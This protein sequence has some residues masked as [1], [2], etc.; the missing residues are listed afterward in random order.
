MKRRLLGIVLLSL[1]L[2]AVAMPLSS[3]GVEKKVKR[4]TK[5][6]D[7]ENPLDAGVYDST[8]YPLHFVIL[9]L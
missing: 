1:L 4:S 3:C 5:T 6:D 7:I 8:D 9:C 2:V